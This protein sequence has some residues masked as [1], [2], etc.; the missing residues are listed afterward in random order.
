MPS[1]LAD[2]HNNSSLVQ[3]TRVRVRI[4]QLWNDDWGR[5]TDVYIMPVSFARILL[6][7]T[8]AGLARRLYPAVFLTA[9]T[10]A[11]SS[12]GAQ[13]YP[14]HNTDLSVGG[15]EQFTT[16]LTIP[17]SELSQSVTRS[18][19]L[20]ASFKEHPSLWLGFEVNYQYSK[21]YEVPQPANFGSTTQ[22]AMSLQECT[23]AYL[24]HP[25]SGSL[26]PFVAIGGGELYFKSPASSNGQFRPTAL[27]DFGVDIPFSNPHF[28]VSLHGHTLYYRAP[29]A[30]DP[31]SKTMN[32]VATTEPSA[33]FYIRF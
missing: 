7:G 8:A 6:L 16:P 22:T 27:L 17:V 26:Q 2:K 21:L 19:A 1:R 24:L 29:D 18:P 28:G 10:M 14:L 12:A 20:L 9:L 15:T 5:Q 13:Y 23:A 11:C 32:W 33:D 3:I 30:A 4:P 25:R 31:S